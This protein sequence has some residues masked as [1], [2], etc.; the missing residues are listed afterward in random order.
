MMEMAPRWH[1]NNQIAD[2]VL[3]ARVCRG[4]GAAMHASS[5]VKVDVVLAVAD[6]AGCTPAAPMSSSVAWC[7]VEDGAT[8]HAGRL[9][10]VVVIAPHG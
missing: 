2:I 7:R 10:K 6:G 8:L 3:V 5:L 1:G 9:V 4:D